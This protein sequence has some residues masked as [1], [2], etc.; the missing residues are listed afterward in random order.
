MSRLQINDNFGGQQLRTQAAPRP[1]TPSD[2]ILTFAFGDAQINIRAVKDASGLPWFIF[3]DVRQVLGLAKTGRTLGRLDN[4]DKGV[5][6]LL[7]PGGLQPFATINEA[8]LF[9]LIFRSHKPEALA[10]KRWVTG[11]VLPAI[12]MD[13]IYIRGE[14]R[15]ALADATPEQLQAQLAMLQATMRKG[16]ERKAERVGLCA[17]EERDARHWALRPNKRRSSERSFSEPIE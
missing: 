1:N 12:R 17:A 8:G 9:A 14:E 7:T 16:L 5:C 15:L 10:F 4:A 11:V 3:Q 2:D 13:G 6:Q